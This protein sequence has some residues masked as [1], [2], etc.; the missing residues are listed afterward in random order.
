MGLGLEP[1]SS[2]ARRREE[3]KSKLRREGSKEGKEEAGIT[4]VPVPLAA[5]AAPGMGVCLDA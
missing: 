4:V 5:A 3:M 1:S 2:R